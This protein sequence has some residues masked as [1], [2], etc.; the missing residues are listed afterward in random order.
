MAPSRDIVGKVEDRAFRVRAESLE[1]LEIISAMLQ[2]AIVPI[3]EIAWRRMDNRFVMITQRFRWEK[4]VRD[5]AAD[6]GPDAL[7]DA[8]RPSAADD[9]GNDGENSEPAPT[10]WFERI[11]CALRFENVTAVRANGIDLANR[12]QM[13]ELLSLH[14]GDGGLDLAF[15]DGKTIRLSI[16]SLSCHAEDIGQPWPTTLRP[17][18]PEDEE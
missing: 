17:E 13:L 12:G 18:H 8:P 1:D 11:T 3:S 5:G 2:D 14:L 4:A 6:D 15:A 9:G 7:G 10:D 16:S